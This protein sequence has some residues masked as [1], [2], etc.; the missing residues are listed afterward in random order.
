MNKDPCTRTRALP[1]THS[2]ARHTPNSFWHCLGSLKNLLFLRDPFFHPPF[3]F[4]VFL[5]SF[6]FPCES[7]HIF[8]LSVWAQK[9]SHA[10]RLINNYRVHKIGREK[11]KQ[12]LCRLMSDMRETKITKRQNAIKR[13]E[14]LHIPLQIL[15]FCF[16]LLL[17][18]LYPL[19]FSFLFFHS[20]F[21]LYKSL[22]LLLW[23]WEVINDLTKMQT[24]WMYVCAGNDCS[25]L[26]RHTL[27]FKSF[28]SPV[29]LI[30]FF[31]SFNN[32]YFNIDFKIRYNSDSKC[33]MNIWNGYGPIQVMSTQSCMTGKYCCI[34]F[35]FNFNFEFVFCFFQLKSRVEPLHGIVNIL[36]SMY[37]TNVFL[38]PYHE[39]WHSYAKRTFYHLKHEWPFRNTE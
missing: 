26:Y 31:F 19:S 2:Q 18:F 25:F 35:V 34:N 7:L 16:F 39:K 5:F 15:C 37:K 8:F 3:S 12:F 24:L 21:W 36:F 33:I 9:T 38:Q 23:L 6:F 28:E 30:F 13:S 32:C 17:L 14:S 11:K 1:Y 10:T 22:E 20:L 29:T 27:P 4:P